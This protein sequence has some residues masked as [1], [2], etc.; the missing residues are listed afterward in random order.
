MYTLK[1]FTVP[2]T[3]STFKWSSG[4]VMTLQVVL[5]S[6]CWTHL[7]T[8]PI[9]TKNVPPTQSLECEVKVSFQLII[10]NSLHLASHFTAHGS[11]KITPGS[12][13]L[14]LLDYTATEPSKGKQRSSM[15]PRGWYRRGH[16]T[17]LTGST[18]KVTL[19]TMPE[20]I[21]AEIRGFHT[22]FPYLLDICIYSCT[23]RVYNYYIVMWSW[24]P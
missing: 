15:W 3:H 9:G 20:H 22:A 17:Q 5:T 16:V 14:C 11:L 19:S 21:L 8:S 18:T 12:F 7:R 24:I 6:H 23:Y 2:I 13:L 10:T 4:I 1:H